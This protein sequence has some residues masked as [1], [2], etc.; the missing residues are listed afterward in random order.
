VSEERD[1]AARFSAY[2]EALSGVI[3]HAD[4]EKPL[5]DYCRGLLTPCER[6][7]VE[8]LAAITA[9]ERTRSI[10]APDEEADPWPHRSG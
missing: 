10:E 5:S 2:V 8:P 9:P 6:K 4:R 3:G 7:S 1:P